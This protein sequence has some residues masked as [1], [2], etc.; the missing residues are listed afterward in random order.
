MKA[1][2]AMVVFAG[3]DQCKKAEDESSGVHDPD[4]STM[5]KKNWQLG[6]LLFLF[7]FDKPPRVSCIE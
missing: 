6:V 3:E 5:Q 2:D 1:L 4:K 7:L